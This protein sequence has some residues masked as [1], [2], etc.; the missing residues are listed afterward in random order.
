MSPKNDEYFKRFH[1]GHLL[2]TNFTLYFGYCET[3]Q[4]QVNQSVTNI[5]EYS[6][7]FDIFSNILSY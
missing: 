6:N 4:K 7:I 3:V 5:F 1:G 2:I